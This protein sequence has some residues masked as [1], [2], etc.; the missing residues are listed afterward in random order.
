MQ[1][2]TP[3]R[4]PPNM[5]QPPDTRQ[6]KPNFSTS[7]GVNQEG[8]FTTSQNTYVSQNAPFGY[9]FAHSKIQNISLSLNIL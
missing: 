9:T 7:E 5:I 2:R 3:F 1:S 6:K 8:H 4:T